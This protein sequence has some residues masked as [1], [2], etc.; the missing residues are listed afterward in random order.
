MTDRINSLALLALVAETRSRPR[1][2]PAT[3]ET[4]AET[5]SPPV[6]V[7]SSHSIAGRVATPGNAGSTGQAQAQGAADPRGTWICHRWFRQPANVALLE[8]MPSYERG[9]VA[10]F[11]AYLERFGPQVAGQPI[12]DSDQFQALVFDQRKRLM[13]DAIAMPFSDG[14]VHP[15][16]RGPVDRHVARVGLRHKTRSATD[17]YRH[18]LPDQKEVMLRVDQ[19]HGLK[20]SHRAKYQTFITQL[21]NYKPP[22]PLDPTTPINSAASYAALTLQQKKDLVSDLNSNENNKL[23]KGAA[24]AVKTVEQMLFDQDPQLPQAGSS[25]ASGSQTG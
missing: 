2:L 22:H 23:A 8:G 17:K 7:S 4:P 9:Y 18:L 6:R 16:A 11:L 19:L 20:D 24:N 15:N 1:S 5:S 14:G 21:K 10:D 3:N 12:V 13:G 25:V